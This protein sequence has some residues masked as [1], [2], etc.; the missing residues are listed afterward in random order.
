MLTGP[1]LIGVFLL[2]IAILLVSIIKFR[3]NAFI[4][5]LITSL[6]T[7]ILV[8]M[9]IGDIASTISGGFGSTLSGIGIV[10][11]LGVMLGKFMF[12]CG[13]IETISNAILNKFGEKNS[14]AAIAISGFL[15]GIPVFGDVV[16]IM[17]APML[18]VLSKK[19]NISMVTFACAISVAT[20]CTYSLVIPTPAPLVV[21]ES[22]GID[23]GIF[24]V[25][26]IL[27]AFVAT[28]TGG[29]LYGKFLDKQDKKNGH[30]YTFEDIEEIEDELEATKETRPMPSFMKSLS[31]L[32]VPIMLILLGSFVPLALGDN[33]S[34]V[35]L[36]KFLGDK[37][38][39]MLIGVIYAA[40]ISKPYITRSI[41]DI[42]NDAADQIGLILLITGAGGAFGKVL[43]ATGIADYIAGSLSQFSIPILLLCF[44]ISQIIR[45]AQGSTTVALMTTASILS[46]TIAASSVSPILCAI[47]IC[48]GGIGLS[49]PN[50]S[51][52]WAIS[53]FFK[54]SVQDTI[55]GWTVGGFIA[56]LSALAF[57][58]ILSLFQ[59][60][61]PGLL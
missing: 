5:L 42:M 1:L 3:L 35:P 27:T 53:R 45:C 15:T 22:L 32:L 2:A 4:A 24:F 40:L 41:S 51:G 60:V 39:A 56:G 36:V 59:N 23:V 55:R 18:R 21:S 43:Q 37:N 33:N 29:I 11:G 12:E 61:L 58:S 20:T 47:A 54:I 13:A 31:I 48:A 6:V 49:L 9:P 7:S 14:P 52:F 34:V 57:I 28:I 44:L 46:G 8:G 16:Y 26:A 50:D 17:F 10:T 25:Y 38:V 19:T 30:F